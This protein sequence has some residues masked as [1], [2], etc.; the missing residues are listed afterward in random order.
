LANNGEALAAAAIAGQGIFYGPRFITAAAI[1]E[2]RLRVI[3]LDRPL[4]DHGAIY[5][6]TQSKRRPAAKTRAFIDYLVQELPKQQ[7]C[8]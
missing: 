1:G 2:G 3:E 6:V 7:H 4:F 5:A 8:F